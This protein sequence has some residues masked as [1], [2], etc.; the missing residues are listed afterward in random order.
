MKAYSQSKIAVGLFGREL[1]ARSRAGGWGITSNISHP[2]VSPTNLLAAQP[3][4]GRPK[5]GL[6][7]RVIRF[8]SR[9]GLVGTPE[10]AALPA[11]RAATDPGVKGDEFYG[12]KGPGG[13]GGGP[14]RQELWPPL[15]RMDDAN[16]LWAASER[17]AGV[18]FAA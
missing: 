16:R 10:T 11:L 6:S 7:I 1:D 9:L 2:G 14:A 8:L 17:L 12:P 18:R 3:G 4:L 15:R 5:D 13:V